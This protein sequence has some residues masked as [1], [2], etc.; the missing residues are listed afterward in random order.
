MCASCRSPYR[1][2]SWGSHD[3]RQAPTSSSSTATCSSP[4]PTRCSARRRCRGRA[5]GDLAA[6]VRGRPQPGARRPRLVRIATRLTLNRMRTNARRRESYVGPGCEPPFHHPDV[7]EDVEL[8]DSVPLALTRVRDAVADRAGGVQVPG[9]GLRLPG[10]TR[11]RRSTRPAAVRQVAH[12]AR[13][14]VDER[15]PCRPPGPPSTDRAMQGFPSPRVST[16]DVQGI[17]RC[18]TSCS[19]PADGGGVRRAL[20]DPREVSAS[21]TRGDHGHRAVVD[22][23]AKGAGRCASSSTASS[24]RS[25]RWSSGTA[26]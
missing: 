2:R 19:S 9:E 3:R 24:T 7:A 18:P 21:S 8:A 17:R 14:H 25:R 15:R 16:G 13:A 10:T 1:R 12:R 22:V 20:Y 26:W 4:S 11:S 6:M 23:E 5:A